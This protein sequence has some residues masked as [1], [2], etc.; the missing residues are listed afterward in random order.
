MKTRTIP[1]LS[2]L[3]LCMQPSRPYVVLSNNSNAQWEAPVS[4]KYV[5]CFWAYILSCY[6]ARY[7][8]IS[9]CWV[10]YIRQENGVKLADIMF[11]LLSVGL[12]VG[13]CAHGCS[14][15]HRIHSKIRTSN[16]THGHDPSKKFWKGGMG[17]VTWPPKFLGVKCQLLEYS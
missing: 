11:S 14:V 4:T 13:L 9:S 8:I 17:R 10:C 6:Y 1:A 12:S 7:W 15:S 2:N 3:D 16:L 5:L